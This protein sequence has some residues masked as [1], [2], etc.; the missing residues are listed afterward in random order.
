MKYKQFSSGLP[1]LILSLSFAL[2]L[3]DGKDRLISCC[4]NGRDFRFF[5]ISYVSFIINTLTFLL[6]H[7]LGQHLAVR[8]HQLALDIGTPFYPS[9]QINF[10][11]REW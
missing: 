6:S 3:R 1:E 10:A 5:L 11:V 8:Q 4:L 9:A 2:F 7:Q